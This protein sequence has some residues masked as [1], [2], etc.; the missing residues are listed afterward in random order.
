MQDLSLFWKHH[1]AVGDKAGPKA[2]GEVLTK[3]ELG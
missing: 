1:Q 2:A 3:A